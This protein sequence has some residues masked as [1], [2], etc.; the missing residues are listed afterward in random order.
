L[1]KILV[2]CAIGLAG[3]AADSNV[4]TSGTLARA[5]KE[6]GDSI[7]YWNGDEAVGQ[8]SIKVNLEDQRAY[9]YKGHQIV[10]V[11]VVST[12]REGYR[13]PPG[14]FPRYAEGS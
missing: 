5:R 10:G 2:V 4:S 13:T 8:P 6:K 3:C 7:S 11:S 14:E 9:F 12:G 1:P